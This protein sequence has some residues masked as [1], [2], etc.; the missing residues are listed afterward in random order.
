MQDLA[1]VDL[2]VLPRPP[3]API[4]QSENFIYDSATRP[5]LPDLHVDTGGGG[6]DADHGADDDAYTYNYGSGGGATST[7]PHYRGSLIATQP[8]DNGDI[9]SDYYRGSMARLPERSWWHRCSPETGKRCACLWHNCR[10]VSVICAALGVLT[11]LV[12]IVWQGPLLQ[13]AHCGLTDACLPCRAPWPRQLPTAPY[14]EAATTKT[15]TVPSPGDGNATAS[16]SD[17]CLAAYFHPAVASAPPLRPEWAVRV[18]ITLRSALDLAGLAEQL[19]HARQLAFTG[20]LEVQSRGVRPSELCA[21]LTAEPDQGLV[22]SAVWRL[23]G[24]A[25]AAALAANWTLP[26]ATE[27]AVAARFGHTLWLEAYEFPSLAPADDGAAIAWLRQRV[28]ATAAANGT[29]WCFPVLDFHASG[30][31]CEPRGVVANHPYRHR[32]QPA[33]G[34]SPAAVRCLTPPPPPPPPSGATSDDNPQ[35][36]PTALARAAR[37]DETEAEAVAVAYTPTTDPYGPDAMPPPDGEAA[38]A[39]TPLRIHRYLSRSFQQL[40]HRRRRAADA[41]DDDDGTLA[42]LR[43]PSDALSGWAF[44][45]GRGAAASDWAFADD[46]LRDST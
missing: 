28:T 43:T 10:A 13:L 7:H 5:P 46:D 12:W 20:R 4:L 42:R 3:R 40:Y 15:T 24:A 17:A 35:S 16:L 19:R 21:W 33:A 14:N 44:W 41:D 18:H 34:A 38:L 6:D 8:F 39:R 2:S 29:A 1:P 22:Q 37:Y 23:A 25:G 9:L 26:A 31:T 27:A 32:L 30:F 11:L 45:T 36:P